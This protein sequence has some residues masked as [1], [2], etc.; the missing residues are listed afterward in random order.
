[1]NVVNVFLVAISLSCC[2]PIYSISDLCYPI[3]YVDKYRGY[4]VGVKNN[5]YRIGRAIDAIKSG[6][7]DLPQVLG[8]IDNCSSEVFRCKS[9]GYLVFAVPKKE[10]R[11]T[12]YKG[13]PRIVIR[14]LESGGWDGSAT[15]STLTKN[16]CAHRVDVEKAVVT[17]QY[18]VDSDGV[19]KSVNIQNWNGKGMLINAQNL[20]LVSRVGL[21]LK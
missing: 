11:L 1:M 14:P 19:L 18:R 17:Y 8:A 10:A 7:N 9:I 20:V 12:V 3:K 5:R 6:S 15:C 16:G 13:G 4:F 2:G 21:R